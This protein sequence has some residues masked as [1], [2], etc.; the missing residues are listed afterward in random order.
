MQFEIKATKRDVQGSSASRRLRHA[1]RVPGI[2][3]GGKAAPQMVEFDH[4]ELY[5]ALRKEA[6]HS[7]VINVNVAGAKEMCL[8][9]DVQRH[10]Y[11][12]Q[13]KHVDFQRIDAEH[14]IHLKVPLHFINAE[15]ATGVKLDGGMVQHVMTELDVRCLPK[16]LPEFIEVDLKDMKG[17]QPL[18]VS[19]LPLPAGV[20]VVRH[21][22]GDPVVVS[23]VV[24]GSAGA[25]TEEAPAPVVTA[26]PA[27]PERKAERV[28]RR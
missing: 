20:E 4:N 18:H 11:K 19:Q 21:G 17:G 12:L 27:K 22:E 5:Q 2:L 7:S 9:R 15:I 24:R 1:G 26:A 23:I 6:F 16:D 28:D 8:L 10:A 25:E 3:Y 14:K 13:I